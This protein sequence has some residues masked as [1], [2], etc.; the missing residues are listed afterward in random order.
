M[1]GC[2]VLILHYCTATDTC[3]RYIA[4]SLSSRC[5]SSRVGFGCFLFDSLAP[6]LLWLTRGFSFMIL[7]KLKGPIE[8]LPF[9]L[10]R[11]DLLTLSV[12]PKARNSTQILLV[13]ASDEIYQ[14]P[15]PQIV[16]D[17]IYQKS[18]KLLRRCHTALVSSRPPLHGAAIRLASTPISPSP[19]QK[20]GNSQRARESMLS[21][22]S[23]RR[24]VTTDWEDAYGVAI[25][26]EWPV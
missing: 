20:T 22:R 14:Q 16:N 4:P 10:Q 24:G 26:L 5:Q 8:T 6:A 12:L 11:P 15:L 19:L 3:G 2:Q 23:F 17:T 18:L 25:R 13:L 1:F 21:S 9:H 7:R